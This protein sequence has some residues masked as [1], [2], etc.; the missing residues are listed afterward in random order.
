MKMQF[1]IVGEAAILTIP[2]P[3]ELLEIVK[4]SNIV[5][6]VIKRALS[7]LIIVVP[8]PLSL[9]KFTEMLR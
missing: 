1:V 6:L 7:F 9:V 3:G 4:P 2:Q 8:L 5:E